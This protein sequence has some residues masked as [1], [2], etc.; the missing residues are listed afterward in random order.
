MKQKSIFLR[1]ACA[2]LTLITVLCSCSSNGQS[3]VSSGTESQVSGISWRGAVCLPFSKKDSLNPFKAETKQNKELTKLLFDPLIKINENFDAEA[4]IAE[5]YSYENKKCTVKLKAISFTDGRELTADDVLYSFNHAKSSETYSKQLEQISASAADSKTVVFS[6]AYSDPN[7][8][9][10]LDFP[11]IKSGS[12]DLKDDNNRSIPPIG[13]GRYL[14][15]DDSGLKLTANP[16]YYNGSISV[17]S[18]TLVDCP[19]DSSLSHY[20]ASGSI[21][22]IYSDMSD[23]TVPKKSGDSLKI[24]TTNLVF[25]GVNC[26]KEK[27]SD[28]KMRLAISSAIDRTVICEEGYYGYAN[29]ASGIFPPSWSQT[30]NFESINVTQN[31]E[32]TVAYFNAIGYN[33]TDSDGYLADENGSKLSFTLMYN[34]DNSARAA[35]AAKIVTQLKKCGVE[36]IL[37]EVDYSTYSSNLAS[38]NYELYIGEIKLPKSLYLGSILSS[39][40]IPGY[41]DSSDAVEMFRQYYDG[42][43]EIG[44]AVSAFASEMPFIPLCYRCGV[45]VASDWLSDSLKVSI[46]DVYNGIENCK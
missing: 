35:S 44:A 21:S 16:S 3:S 15:A 13:C 8:I 18:I 10:L 28:A 20:A 2:T 42:T 26:S 22:A 36:I 29:A 33:D 4:F 23:N 37:N 1:L 7:M 34:G 17:D 41:P 11:I 5:S 32:Q 24:P 31:I 25:I 14:F 19:D 6:I 30:K 38:G 27:L 45:T 39:S 46:S 9:N 43:C 40:V 12:A